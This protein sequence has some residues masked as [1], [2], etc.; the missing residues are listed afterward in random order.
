MIWMAERWS[1]SA[2]EEM[3]LLLQSIAL[4]ITSLSLVIVFLPFRFFPHP[5]LDLLSALPAKR[6]SSAAIV[7]SCSTRPRVRSKAFRTSRGS[8]SKTAARLRALL[9][10]EGASAVDSF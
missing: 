9:C 8:K 6:S 4:R 5:F 1:P 7:G 2:R 10:H 3:H